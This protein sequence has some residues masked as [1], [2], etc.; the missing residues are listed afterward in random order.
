MLFFST[1]LVA[2]TLNTTWQIA[3]GKRAC[4]SEAR[5][6]AKAQKPCLS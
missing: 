1:I 3:M 5:R 2:V 4:P 6:D